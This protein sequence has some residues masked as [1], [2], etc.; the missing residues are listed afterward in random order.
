MTM[1]ASEAVQFIEYL[2]YE[3]RKTQGELAA[4]IGINRS[5]ICDILKGKRKLSPT[6]IGKIKWYR[7]KIAE[8][9]T[10]Y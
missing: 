2:I 4:A 9:F 8:E 1:T 3:K 6:T 5:T 10:K 7:N